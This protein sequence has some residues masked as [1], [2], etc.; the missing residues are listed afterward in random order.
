[1]TGVR[2]SREYIRHHEKSNSLRN[3]HAIVLSV[4]FSILFSLVVS[5]DGIND[6]CNVDDHNDS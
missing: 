3:I 5:D 6:G 4:F 1:M 2:N